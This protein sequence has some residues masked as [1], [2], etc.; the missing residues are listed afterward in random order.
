MFKIIFECQSCDKIYTNKTSY[1]KQVKSCSGIKTPVES[2]HCN[3]FD[4]TFSRNNKGTYNNSLKLLYHI[5]VN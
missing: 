1:K 2:F 3:D 4:K 5:L